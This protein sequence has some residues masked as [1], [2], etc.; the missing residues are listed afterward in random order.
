VSLVRYIE[1]QNDG[2]V[3]AAVMME[4]TLGHDKRLVFAV[5]AENSTSP[6]MGWHSTGGGARYASL[7][8]ALRGIRFSI[9][10]DAA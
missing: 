4:R 7:S 10:H 2:P 5:R 8:F 1:D 6:S 3:G 9:L